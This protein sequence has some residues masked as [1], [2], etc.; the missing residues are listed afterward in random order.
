ME[1]GQRFVVL[2]VGL[3]SVPFWTACHKRRPIAAAPPPPEPVASAAIKP[4]PPTISEFTTDPNRIERGQSA[5]LRWQVA[6]ATQI[7]IDQGLGAVSTSGTRSVS[8]DASTTY[9]LKATGPGGTV[10]GVTTLDVTSPAPPIATEAAPRMPLAERLANEVVDAYF[11]FDQY[12][13]RQDALEALRSDAAALKAIFDG[14]PNTT[15]VIEGHCDER[16]S[17]EYNVGLGDRRASAVKLFLMESGVPGEH[18]VMISY[19]KDRPQCSE[20]NES[21]WQRNRR[22][23]FVPGERETRTSNQSEQLGAGPHHANPIG[24]ERPTPD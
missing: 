14:F 19:G 12:V 10:T 6:D 5:L 16:G 18:L 11:D 3:L 1:R 4:N 22:V 15:V 13:L 9:T 7:Q 21:C 24:A 20:A 23:H 17:A 2:A 8:P